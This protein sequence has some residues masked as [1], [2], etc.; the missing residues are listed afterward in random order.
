MLNLLFIQHQTFLFGKKRTI[1][2]HSCVKVKKNNY[3]CSANEKSKINN[4]Y[5]NYLG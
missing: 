4:F 2:F 1:F 3:L 5:L